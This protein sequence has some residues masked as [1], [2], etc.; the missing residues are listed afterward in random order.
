MPTYLKWR[1]HTVG[2]TPTFARLTGN[3]ARGAW[4]NGVRRWGVRSDRHKMLGGTAVQEVLHE[5]RGKAASA[6]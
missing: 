2:H 1:K 3:R 5:G 4:K 6:H